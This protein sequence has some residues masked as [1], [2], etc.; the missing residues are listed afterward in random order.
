[1][2]GALQYVSKSRTYFKIAISEFR[3][4]RDLS[5][6]G[7]IGTEFVKVL[8]TLSHRI[9]TRTKEPYSEVISHLRTRLRF[10]LLRSCLIALRGNRRKIVATSLADA[11]L[12]VWSNEEEELLWRLQ[13]DK[14]PRSMFSWIDLWFYLDPL[15]CV[16]A[17]SLDSNWNSWSS[18]TQCPYCRLLLSS[19]EFIDSLVVLLILFSSLTQSMSMSLLYGLEVK[20]LCCVCWFRTTPRSTYLAPLE[21]KQSSATTT[22]EISIL[23]GRAKK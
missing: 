14:V 20:D 7:G 10:A 15:C 3:K 8:Q 23:M 9:S 11:E 16:I 18:L 4:S 17:L 19:L 5:N 1:M 2:R 21:D 22:S 13:E 6:S 12:V